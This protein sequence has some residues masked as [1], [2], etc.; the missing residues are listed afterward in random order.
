MRVYLS[1][2]VDVSNL[3]VNQC[4]A[5]EPSPHEIAA[6]HGTHKCHNDTSKVSLGYLH[7]LFMTNFK[8]A[9][10]FSN[11]PRHFHLNELCVL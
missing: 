4:E 2:D 6:F 5:D 11:P 7:V 1:L 10:T 3:E 9:Y 8:S